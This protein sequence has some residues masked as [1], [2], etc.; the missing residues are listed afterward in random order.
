V[1]ETQQE[2]N[3]YN[4]GYSFV[5]DMC[6]ATEVSHLLLHIILVMQLPSSTP[7]DIIR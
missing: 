6:C 5:A 1:P 2:G 3:A 4:N 7:D